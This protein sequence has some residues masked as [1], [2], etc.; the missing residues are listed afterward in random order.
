MKKVDEKFV[1]PQRGASLLLLL[2]LSASAAQRRLTLR[3]GHRPRL[4]H[5]LPTPLP[6]VPAD[7]PLLAPWFSACSG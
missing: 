1:T 3:S 4:P 7:T 5:L 6:C 2:L